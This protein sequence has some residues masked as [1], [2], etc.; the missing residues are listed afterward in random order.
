MLILSNYA[1][2]KCLPVSE[3]CFNASFV[4][5]SSYVCYRKSNYSFIYCNS[6]DI[7]YCN[8]P[9]FWSEQI[10]YDTHK[11][12]KRI[13]TTY[14]KSTSDKWRG[15]E[16]ARCVKWNNKLYVTVTEPSVVNGQLTRS[17]DIIMFK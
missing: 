9:Y 2:Y 6:K 3:S 11:N 10:L 13:L 14:N 4:P 5:D 15:F 12:S 16:D 17:H 8:E 7:T 1:T